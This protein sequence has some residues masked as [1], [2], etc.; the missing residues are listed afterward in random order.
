[1]HGNIKVISGK[2]SKDFNNLFSQKTGGARAPCAPPLPTGLNNSPGKHD[3]FSMSDTYEA[4]KAEEF[5]LQ[6]HFLKVVSF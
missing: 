4:R 5:Q 1:M 6:K 3:Y 2:I